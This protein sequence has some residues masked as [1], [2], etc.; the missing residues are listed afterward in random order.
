MSEKKGPLFSFTKMNKYY[1]LPFIT[2][3][4]CF[5]GNLIETLILEEDDK[6]LNLF[7]FAIIN[8]IGDILAGFIY[9]IQLCQNKNKNL[10]L[11]RGNN[12]EKIKCKVFYYIILMSFLISPMYICYDLNLDLFLFLPFSFD[13]IFS[14]VFSIF[15]LKINIY[16]HQILSII[17]SFIGFILILFSNTNITFKNFYIHI[18]ISLLNSTFIS[19]LKYSTTIYFISP[20]LCSFYYGIISLI[21]YIIGNIV[22]D[23]YISKEYTFLQNIYAFNDKIFIIYFSLIIITSFL[24]KILTLL[25]VNY[26]SP[27]L[28]FISKTISPML[29][30]FYNEL[31]VKANKQSIYIYILIII[32]F[33]FEIISILLYNEIIIINAYGLN[34]NTVK[35][36]KEREIEENISLL[37]DDEIKDKKNR[38]SNAYL[39]ISNYMVNLEQRTTF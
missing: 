5:I 13:L 18:I 28:Y 7:F 25:E 21:I 35:Y 27:I 19:I 33:L 22:Y 1:L 3:V 11:K 31:I 38:N 24:I 32:G 6:K 12:K 10:N 4:F 26:F 30:S 29:F 23:L 36:I 20:F 17:I 15:L 14:I 8:S 39:E 2:P 37:Y 16:K 9:F 34:K